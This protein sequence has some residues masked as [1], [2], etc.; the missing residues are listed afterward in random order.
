MDVAG[1]SAA[2]LTIGAPV[3][4]QLIYAFGWRGMFFAL[5]VISAVWIPLWLIF[6][7]DDP[8]QSRFVSRRKM[9]PSAK[10]A[11]ASA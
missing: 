3:S 5:T 4:T 2:C 7:R 10:P 1:R 11:S 9:S 6:F 8:A